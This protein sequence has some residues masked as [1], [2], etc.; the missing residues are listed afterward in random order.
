MEMP[1]L[2]YVVQN[3]LQQGGNQLYPIETER[4]SGIFS[5]ATVHNRTVVVTNGHLPT[6]QSILGALCARQ[7]VWPRL[8]GSSAFYLE[9][10]VWLASILLIPDPQPVQPPRFS[11]EC[12][13]ENR[14]QK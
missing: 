13:K 12:R 6:N 14:E 7:C 3:G 8:L 9:D 10:L 5:A 11:R 1:A 4:L 2:W